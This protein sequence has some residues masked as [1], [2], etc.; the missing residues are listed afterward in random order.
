M[1]TLQVVYTIQEVYAKFF[2]VSCTVSY[3]HLTGSVHYMYK[4]CTQKFSMYPVQCPMYTLQV[5]YIILEVYAK[6][7][8]VSCTVFYVHITGS[9]DCKNSLR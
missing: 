9:V 1:Y 5:E 2:N 8:N 4:K 7:F 6:F 3:V